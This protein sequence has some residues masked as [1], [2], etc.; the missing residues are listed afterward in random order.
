ML[1]IER[2]LELF[3]DIHGH[4]RK[5]NSFMYACSVSEVSSDP[6]INAIIKSFPMMFSHKTSYFQYKDCKFAVEKEK[7]ETARVVLFKELSILNSYTLEVS[8][9]GYEKPVKTTI[10]EDM[11]EDQ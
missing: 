8:F 7:E 2:S 5:L 1:D 4:S 11:E 6:K 9:F 10:E 3:T